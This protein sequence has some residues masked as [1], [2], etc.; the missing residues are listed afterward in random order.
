[1]KYY[2]T[3]ILALIALTLNAQDTKLTINGVEHRGTK[4]NDGTVD[5][6]TANAILV[7]TETLKKIIADLKYYKVLAHEDSIKIAELTKIIDASEK[8]ENSADTLINSQKAM[9]KTADSLYN[10]YKDLYHDLKRLS[11]INTFSITPG[12]GVVNIPDIS[13]QVSLVFNL[14]FEYQK[15]N[16]NAL[17]G[18]KYQGLT[19][20][21]RIGF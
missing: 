19:V 8:F 2:L 18:K 16:L 15:V 21:Y 17:V 10:G 9:I 3:L 14:G 11:D 20:G 6:A 4:V 1:M 7:P 5:F 12:I 13:P